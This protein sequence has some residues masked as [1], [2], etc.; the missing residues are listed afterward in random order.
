MANRHL[1]SDYQPGETVLMEHNAGWKETVTIV[2]E[3]RPA[4]WDVRAS[5][6]RIYECHWGYL[7]AFYKG[8]NDNDNKRAD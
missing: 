2:A 5:S 8:E 4:H 7:W 3:S 6:G 1:R